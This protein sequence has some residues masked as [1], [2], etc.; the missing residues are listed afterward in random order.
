MEFG[1]AQDPGET[2]VGHSDGRASNFVYPM[3]DVLMAYHRAILGRIRIYVENGVTET[4]LDA[5]SPSPTL[6]NNRPV[7]GR[8]SA[9]IQQGSWTSA[10][11][12]TCVV[13]SKAMACTTGE[14]Q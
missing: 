10:R 12:S 14:E 9:V 3:G 2:G 8:I 5:W 7:V 4:D 1:R 6:K 11:R 13:C